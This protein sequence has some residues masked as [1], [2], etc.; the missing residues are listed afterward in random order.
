MWPDAPTVAPPWRTGSNSYCQVSNTR[1]ISPC[2]RASVGRLLTASTVIVEA[3][4]KLSD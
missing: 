1:P 3:N 4:K 2:S